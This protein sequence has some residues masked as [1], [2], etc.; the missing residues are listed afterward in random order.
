VWNVFRTRDD[1][2]CELHFH[3]ANAPHDALALSAHMKK[4]LKKRPLKKE[5]YQKKK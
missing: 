5:A 1:G 4:D 2:T 3:D